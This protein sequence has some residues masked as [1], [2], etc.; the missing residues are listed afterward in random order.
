MLR[1][2]GGYCLVAV[3][4]SFCGC[5][6]FWCYKS[7]KS[8]LYGWQGSLFVWVG[9]FCIREVDIYSSLFPTWRGT[10]LLHP[11]CLVFL[12]MT[13]FH[14]WSCWSQGP[15]SNGIYGQQCHSLSQ[16][17]MF[18]FDVNSHVMLPLVFTH[19]LW[20]F[21]WMSMVEVI[22]FP[23]IQPREVFLAGCW[24]TMLPIFSCGVISI[25]P[26]MEVGLCGVG[27]I[28]LSH[29]CQTPTY[30]GML[31]CDAMRRSWFWWRMHHLPCWSV[32]S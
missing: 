12:T 6:C 31:T 13:Q 7:M 5:H 2:S 4:S 20:M 30:K 14:E 16:M 32:T 17:H 3:N 11:Q 8:P 29:A 28:H 10:Y 27:L 24:V 9:V 23:L 19:F 22:T 26:P 18:P 1:M 15:L 21:Q 25:S